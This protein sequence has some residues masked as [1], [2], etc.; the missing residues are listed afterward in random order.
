[1]SNYRINFSARGQGFAQHTDPTLGIFILHNKPQRKLFSVLTNSIVFVSVPFKISTNVVTHLICSVW[2]F[3]CK[4]ETYKIEI[5]FQGKKSNSDM[6][7][8]SFTSFTTFFQNW[9][10]TP[11][12][13]DKFMPGND[14]RINQLKYYKWS[15]CDVVANMLDCN[16]IVNEFKL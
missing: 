5:N 1:M 8:F 7:F 14:W 9:R 6:S 16:I 4:F 2:S 12:S 15:L 10:S 11:S 3:N 13:F